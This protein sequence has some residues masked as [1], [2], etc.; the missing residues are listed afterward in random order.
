MKFTNICRMHVVYP[1]TRTP[2]VTSRATATTRR[3]QRT[4]QKKAS[5]A[6]FLSSSSDQSNRK[7]GRADRQ[8][9]GLFL[10][11]VQVHSETSLLGESSDL[12]WPLDS[13]ASR[14]GKTAHEKAGLLSQPVDKA[15]S[16]LFRKRSLEICLAHYHEAAIRDL[17]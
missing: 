14:V 9:F 11:R 16:Q 3:H 12:F 6:L 7:I 5:L 17:L 10:V 4:K 15:A 13:E 1:P 2:T 8:L